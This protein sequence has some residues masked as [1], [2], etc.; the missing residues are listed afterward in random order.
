MRVEDDS[1]KNTTVI[2]ANTMVFNSSIYAGLQGVERYLNGIP[3]LY[4]SNKC[5]V[6]LEIRRHFFPPFTIVS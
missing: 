1:L 5:D 3:V 4:L 6:E 2:L